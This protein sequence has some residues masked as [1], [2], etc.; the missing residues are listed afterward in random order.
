MMSIVTATVICLSIHVASAMETK[1]G[2][3]LMALS[4]EMARSLAEQVAPDGDGAIGRNRVSYF[5]VR[6]QSNLQRLADYAIAGKS[7]DALEKF[8]IASEYAMR[9]QTVDGAFEVVIPA[10][11]LRER[12]PTDSDLA[13]GVAFFAAGAGAGLYA[14]KTSSWAQ[15]TEDARPIIERLAVIEAKLRPTLD[16][17]IKH[18]VALERADRR[19]PNRLLFD[20]M[21]FFTLGRLLGSEE[22][23][24]IGRQFLSLA[25]EQVHAD[26]YFLEGGG[27]DSSYNAVATALAFRLLMIEP[28]ESLEEICENAI[29]WQIS[30]ITE[31]GE[32]LTEGNTRVHPGGEKFLGAEKTLDV[33]YTLEALS[34]SSLHSGN[35]EDTDIAALIRG[36]YRSKR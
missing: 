6:F 23:S 13:S 36:F 32:I 17:L 24:A 27:Y 4:P 9:H 15:Q 3:R 2:D 34:L 10:A 35:D 5:H 1:L 19:A 18:R 12:P 20:S 16:Y 7:I 26:G 14:I 30:R 21:A 28:S 11:L 22:A 29:Q 8:A 33:A 31:R 25:T